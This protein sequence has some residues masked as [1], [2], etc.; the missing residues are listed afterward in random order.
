[1]APKALVTLLRKWGFEGENDSP[2]DS[3]FSE[4]KSEY[5]T[6]L[7]RRFKDPCDRY[8]K[9][10]GDLE[11]TEDVVRTKEGEALDEICLR[12]QIKRGQR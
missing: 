2:I 4:L 6:I 3:H 9:I 8:V 7:E 5:Q 12:L 11:L 10:A 1:M